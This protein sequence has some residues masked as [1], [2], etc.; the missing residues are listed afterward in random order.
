L[1]VWIS[2]ACVLTSC[3]TPGDRRP[4]PELS[5][6][7]TAEP[8][9]TAPDPAIDGD[10][11]GLVD[12]SIA[13][14]E[15]RDDGVV[16]SLEPT[17]IPHAGGEYAFYVNVTEPAFVTIHTGVVFE[18]GA[19]PTKGLLQVVYPNRRSGPVITGQRARIP[20]DGSWIRPRHDLIMVLLCATRRAPPLTTESSEPELRKFLRTAMNNSDNAKHVLMVV[21]GGFKR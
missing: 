16:R 14:V 21:F 19:A 7:A 8:A 11:G 20:S 2:L 13:G 3:A 12:I 18:P 10:Y 17:E 1:A 6:Q 5:P 4:D 9:T 15:T